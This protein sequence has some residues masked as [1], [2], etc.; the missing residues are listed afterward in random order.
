[1][2]A[3]LSKLTFIKL[4]QGVFWKTIWDPTENPTFWYH[5]GMLLS[6][7]VPKTNFSQIQYH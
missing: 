7:I 6:S 1:M 5:E 3:P 4:Q 2:G